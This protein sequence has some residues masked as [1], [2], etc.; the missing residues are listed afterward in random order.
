MFFWVLTEHNVLRIK[1]N[2]MTRAIYSR[3]I[4]FIIDKWCLGI[5]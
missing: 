5:V 4:D 1:D 2:Y 3:S